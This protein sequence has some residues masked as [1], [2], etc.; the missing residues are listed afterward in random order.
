MAAHQLTTNPEEAY[1]NYF[2]D[3]Q[4]FDLNSINN[5]IDTNTSKSINIIHINIRS[6]RKN[7]DEFL[8]NLE[9]TKTKFQVIILTE[10]WLN[11]IVK[12]I[13]IKS[14]VTNLFIRSDQKRGWSFYPDS[15]KHH[16]SKNSSLNCCK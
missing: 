14:L 2:E 9:R 4:Y 15:V 8:I 16:C 11:N 10:T 1:F 12:K 3:C 13:L 5:Y 7:L 6:A